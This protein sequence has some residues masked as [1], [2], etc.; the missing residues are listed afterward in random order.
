[1]RDGLLLGAMLSATLACSAAPPQVRVELIQE[2]TTLSHVPLLLAAAEPLRADN[3]SVGVCVYP[4]PGHH[5][6]GRWTVLTPGG[7][8][9]QV[10]ARAELVN[11]RVV[12]F[13]S[14]SSTGSSLCVHPR[15]GGPLEAAVQRIRVGASTPILVERIVWESSPS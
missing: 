14:P 11:G 6:S 7:H 1:M 10:V 2:P 8:D 13:A 3:D 5:V 15:R 4:G 9:A 12:T